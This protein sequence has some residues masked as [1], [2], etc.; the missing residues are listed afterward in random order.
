MCVSGCAHLHNTVWIACLL[1]SVIAHKTRSIKGQ[2]KRNPATKNK[3][4]SMGEL[5][6]LIRVRL[7]FFLPGTIKSAIMMAET[8]KAVTSNDADQV[9]F[10]Q[11]NDGRKVFARH[12]NKDAGMN[13]TNGNQRGIN[14]CC[15][16]SSL[17][18]SSN[19]PCKFPMGEAV[20][21]IRERRFCG[22]GKLRN[23]TTLVFLQD[24]H[25][26]TST[27][28]GT[29]ASWSVLGRAIDN[30]VNGSIT[31]LNTGSQ[32]TVI[33]AQSYTDV[34]V[35]V[36]VHARACTEKR[37]SCSTKKFL[38]INVFASSVRV[39]FL[40]PHLLGEMICIRRSG[41]RSRLASLSGPTAAAAACM[42]CQHI[43]SVRKFHQ[44]L[45]D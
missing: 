4:T 39:S 33:N 23:V 16:L 35:H 44:G 41:T 10:C 36:L 27:E 14:S 45:T 37:M 6:D 26:R 25:G 38:T 28:W 11:S 40:L 12:Y 1:K 43:M 42:S 32:S 2:A 24:K 22:S 17:I 30:C 8:Q 7:C 20:L 34:D 31:E 19:F 5:L 9:F 21:V 3:A 29:T 15:R 18:L 13:C